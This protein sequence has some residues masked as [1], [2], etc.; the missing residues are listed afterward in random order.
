L[1]SNTQFKHETKNWYIFRLGWKSK[2]YTYT[3]SR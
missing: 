2:F 1:F 3:N